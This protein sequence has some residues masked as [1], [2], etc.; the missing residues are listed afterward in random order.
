MKK[1]KS[2]LDKAISCL[3][4]EPVPAAPPKEAVDATIAKL[5]EASGQSDTVKVEKHIQ[6]IERIKAAGS[7][8]KVAAA[9]VLLIAASYAAGR[10]SAPRQPDVQ[11]LQ[12]A[13]EPAI[14]ESMLEEMNRRWKLAWAGSYVQLKDELNE[15]RRRDLDTYAVQTL[16]ASNAV[17][18]QLLKELIESLNAAQ[19][20]DYNRIARAIYK[21][22]TN[23]LKDKNQLANGLENLTYQTEDKLERNREY[24]LQLL[25]N[26]DL[27]PSPSDN[28]NELKERKE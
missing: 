8:T 13:L 11:Q 24:M 7:F 20:E 5:K 14:R 16:A 1:K 26:T 9:A 12:A 21:I 6:I 10:L 4:K 19:M 22:E 18:N 17:T 28:S 27:V 25:V 15:Q 3:K 23:R 2:I